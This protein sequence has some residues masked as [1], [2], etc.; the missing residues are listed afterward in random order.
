MSLQ[1]IDN[2]HAAVRRLAEGVELYTSAPENTVVRDG[3][4][5]RF[6]FTFELAWKSMKEY[7]EDQGSTAP[8]QFP[9]QVMKEAYAAGIIQDEAVWLDM[10]V[11]RNVTSHIYDDAQAAAVL[12]GIQTRYLSA[13]FALDQFYFPRGCS[14][15]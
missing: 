6:E 3:V 2:F 9:K 14:P 13:L 5:Q 8:L 1:K 7:M 15:T 4:I 10:L 12:N 11:S